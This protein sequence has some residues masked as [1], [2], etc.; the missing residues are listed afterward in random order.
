MTVYVFTIEFWNEEGCE[1][2]V[3]K[4]VYDCEE[5]AHSELEKKLNAQK[6]MWPD[7][8]RVNLLGNMKIALRSASGYSK[9]YSI[10]RKLLNQTY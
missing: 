6:A 2:S 5:T 1:Y 8:Y 9:I 7:S 3:I 10:K 4:G